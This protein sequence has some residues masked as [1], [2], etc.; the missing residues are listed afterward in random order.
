[1]PKRDVLNFVRLLLA[2]V[3]IGGPT[4]WAADTPP[5]P[6]VTGEW[7]PYTGKSVEG[8]GV[9]V[10]I[11]RAV[12]Q[13]MGRQPH[14]EFYPWKRCEAY[15]QH[16]L[17]WATFPYAITAQ[18]LANFRFSD[19]IIEGKE[20]WFYYGEKMKS[21][22]YEDLTDLRPYKIGAVSGY[23]YGDSFREAGLSVDETSEDIAGLRKLRAGRIDL[24]PMNELAG[25]WL[26]NT[27]FAHDQHS[28]GMLTKPLGLNRN[29]LMVSKSYPDSDALLED[30]NS[31]LRTVREDG[32]DER[33]RRRHG[34]SLAIDANDH[35]G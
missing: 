19:P 29:A 23:W 30:F 6:L 21:V 34:L 35:G 27:V 8:E 13:R 32:T 2:C 16:G 26:I 20:V 31:A 22:K 5:I 28:F 10:E 4:A 7:P 15:V 17:A 24:F 11:V 3:A 25:I 12:F 1:M 18:R 9:V 33:I 14:I